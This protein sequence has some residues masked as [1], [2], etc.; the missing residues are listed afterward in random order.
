MTWIRHES[1]VKAR[2]GCRESRFCGVSARIGGNKATKCRGRAFRPD[3]FRS[4]RVA[5]WHKSI[6]P[7][8]PPTARAGPQK[9]NGP[10]G[11][12]RPISPGQRPQPPGPIAFPVDQ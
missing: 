11:P 8:G 9:R 1:V 7:E 2:Q 12:L 6:G 3:V 10:E 4:G 5:T